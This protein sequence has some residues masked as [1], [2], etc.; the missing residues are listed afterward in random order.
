MN[1][2]KTDSEDQEG[3]PSK[4]TSP[5]TKGKE[6]SNT[7]PTDPAAAD[8]EQET[9]ESSVP[10]VSKESVTNP[11]N[12]SDIN[13]NSS[14]LNPIVVPSVNPTVPT[15]A[16]TDNKKQGLA[17]GDTDSG[18]TKPIIL[19]ALS[20]NQTGSEDQP[21]PKPTADTDATGKDNLDTGTKSGASGTEDSKPLDST[22]VLDVSEDQERE[23]ESQVGGQSTTKKSIGAVGSE[24]PK[25]RSDPRDSDFEESIGDRDTSEEAEEIFADDTSKRS[26]ALA[27]PTDEDKAKDKKR[28]RPTDKPI[29]KT[30][31]A[32]KGYEEEASDEGTEDKVAKQ[33]S[34]GSDSKWTPEEQAAIN[35]YLVILG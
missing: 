12:T 8:R 18:T 24:P 10:I 22:G 15:G 28:K 32:A 27:K 26:T 23:E 2:V 9:G 13:N 19:K 29:G 21:I 3:K 31:R 6:D 4:E 34:V 14:G 35:A 30:T 1:L 7:N 5:L 33:T 20:V 17:S 16:V 11:V 25:S